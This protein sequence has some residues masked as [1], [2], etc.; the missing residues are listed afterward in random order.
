MVYGCVLCCVSPPQA[1][2]RLRF[3]PRTGR[4]RGRA[5]RDAAPKGLGW[6]GERAASAFRGH[7]NTN[8]DETIHDLRQIVMRH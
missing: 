4:G 7:T 8:T 6:G 3:D 2:H 1:A 5:G